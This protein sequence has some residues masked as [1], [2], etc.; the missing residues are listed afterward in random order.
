MAHAQTALAL[1]LVAALLC[2]AAAGTPTLGPLA[3]Q[4]APRLA[5]HS[6][7][8]EKIEAPESLLRLRGGFL[9]GGSKAKSVYS[10]SKDGSDGDATMKPLLGGKGANL[11]EMCKIGLS[12][13]PG[14]T[15]STEVC[16][17]YN[18]AGK[19]LTDAVWTE[20]LA[21]LKKVESQMGSKFGDPSAPLLV[22]VRSGAAISMPGMMDTVLN[23][24]M[25]DEV[26]E[27]LAKKSNERFAWDSYRRLLDM[28]GDV[29]MGVH[30]SHFEEALE[31]LKEK[32]GVLTD[33]ELDANDLKEL[34]A[35][36]KEVYK[37][38]GKE[39]PTKPEDQLRKAVEAVFDSW[40]SAR[41]VA[42]RSINQVSGLLGTAVTVQTMVFGNLGS[43]SGTGVL[44][45]RNPSTGEN[46]LYGEY[47]I[48]AQGED[49]VAGI[50]TP[51][52]I[53][54]LQDV[55]PV[56]YKELLE[57][58]N[59]LENHYHDMQDIEFTIQDQK[60]FMLQCRNG[61]RTGPAAVK[62][63]V[64]MYKEGLV[65]KD[66]AINMV[67]SGHL[68]Q[69][70]HPQFADES[71]YKDRV[72]G[73]GLPASPGAA[74]GQVVFTPE[75]AEAFKAQGG[76]AILVRAETSPE[77]VSGMHAAEGI[78]TQRGGMTSHAAV[79]ARGWGKTCVSG[80]QELAVND[81][82]KTMEL[83]GK[84]YTTGDW[85]S[86]NGNTGE[87]IEGRETLAPPTISGD[88]GTFMGWVDERRKVKVFTNADTPEDAAE[89]RR[90]GAQGIGLV[91]TEH[92]FFASDERL[93]A[94]RQMVMA[95]DTTARKKALEKLL[96]FQRADFEGIFKAM[97]SCPVTIRLLDPPLHEFL[98]NGEMKD[99]CQMMANELELSVDAVTDKIAKLSE[100][101]PMLGLR[102]CRLGIVN[103]EITEMQARAIIEAALNVKA[104]GGNPIPDIMVP[105]VGSVPELE[106][107]A[108][109]VRRV[110]EEV[111]AERK[112][113]IEF[114]VGTMIEIPRA[115]LIAGEIAKVADF[116]SFGTN[117]LTQMTFGYSR[118]DVGSFL[119]TYLANNIIPKDPFQV[120]DRHGVGQ[121]IKMAYDNGKA[122]NPNLKC[123]ICGEHGGDPSSI[124]FVCGVGLD[125]VSCSPFRV[126]IARLAAAQSVIRS[127]KEG[128][129]K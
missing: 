53:S 20:V 70:L 110:A 94:V 62:I 57:N 76:A 47:L 73:R 83:G 67:E 91:R 19:K 9:G 33:N 104:A 103:P 45:S 99:V 56:A 43:T 125:Y 75:E 79:V 60:L 115:A 63:A 68:D 95:A 66:D 17:E 122:A 54:T 78:L 46:K 108:G 117:D 96:P 65:S 1:T 80:C 58:V 92:M 6:R 127:E 85:I 82:A 49:V 44:F 55:M 25:N 24:G 15:I 51:D 102:G 61:K 123:G 52:P 34:V 100:V 109:L 23:L 32:K 27:G 69:L 50:R 90:N 88:L 87:V 37:K 31:E 74:V 71:R 10:F 107:Q 119:P 14:F 105:L 7:T 11:A 26:C 48:D 114:R 12:V 84:T 106:H 111:F 39:F 5:Q 118:D 38:A 2:A 81:K 40:D 77:D 93:M 112:D 121:L 72:I 59:K 64:D 41:A 113:R 124:D 4:S 35:A 42:Y 126:P 28:Y 86:L 13:P 120:L 3:R 30:H 21:A 116:F 129:A 128:A 18:K 36:Y 29:V 8:A 89:A 98:P 101:N 22:S 16:N 97:D